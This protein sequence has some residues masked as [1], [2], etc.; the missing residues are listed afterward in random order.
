MASAILTACKASR[1]DPG[2]F[3]QKFNEEELYVGGEEA[4]DKSAELC[5]ECVKLNMMFQ[6]MV[7]LPSMTLHYTE[8]CLLVEILLYHLMLCYIYIHVPEGRNVCDMFI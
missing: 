4:E 2:L 1:Q 7:E 6:T 3:C 5:F 8:M